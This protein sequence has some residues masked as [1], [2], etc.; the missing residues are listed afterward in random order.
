MH[1]IKTLIETLKIFCHLHGRFILIP[2]VRYTFDYIILKLFCYILSYLQLK[3]NKYRS[4]FLFIITPI[5]STVELLRPTTPHHLDFLYIRK[6][7]INIRVDRHRDPEVLN[8]Y[9]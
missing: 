8:M 2:Q 7:T 1:E 5:L 3:I 9:I 4:T 6:T